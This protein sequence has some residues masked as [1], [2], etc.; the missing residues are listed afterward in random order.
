VIL[1]NQ[2][3][4]LALI[5]YAEGTGRNPRTGE[6]LDPYRTCFGYSHTIR[7]FEDHP[8]VTR[9][10]SGEVLPEALCRKAG[11]SGKCRSTAAGRYQLIRPTWVGI[12]NRLRLPDFGPDN[13]DRAALYLIHNR[14]ALEDIHAGRLRDAVRKCKAE[15]AS[16]PGA[17]Y[18][19][20]EREFDSLVAVFNAAGGT[21]A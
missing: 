15:W 19:Q 8:A 16:L 4:F 17:G 3:A 5:E 9:E 11:F 21:L 1:E 14:G 12:K 10:W 18:G 2:R 13:Q 6:K 7:S 20:P